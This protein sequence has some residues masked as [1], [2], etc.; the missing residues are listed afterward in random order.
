MG[1]E[2]TKQTYRLRAATA[3]LVN[4]HARNRALQQ[5]PVRGKRNARC[6]LLLHAI[7]HNIVRGATLRAKE[8]NAA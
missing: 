4:A 7:V 2:A 5:L 8:A 6:V 1:T 3:E